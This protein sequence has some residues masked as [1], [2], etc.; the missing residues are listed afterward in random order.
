MEDVSGVELPL[1]VCVVG[2]ELSGDKEFLNVCSKFGHPVIISNSGGQECVGDTN[3]RT[4][5][6]VNRFS[7][8]EF[9][10]LSDARKPILGPPAVRDLVQN[11]LPLLVKKMPVYC[12]ALYGCVIIFSG[13]RRKADLERLLKLIHWMG[14]SVQRDA[15]KKMTQLLAVSSG[16]LKIRNL[17]SS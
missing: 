6:I 2:E 1:Q 12:L 8:S 5:Y 15:G 7:G 14:G 11:Q 9:D 4:V 3:V 10:R 13:Y 17:P 16:S